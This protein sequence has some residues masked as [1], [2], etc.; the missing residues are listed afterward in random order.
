MKV[1]QPRFDFVEMTVKGY[2]FTWKNRHFIAP[3]A[4]IP[5]LVKL[6]CL[7]LIIALD[8][9]DN[10]LRQGLVLLPSF[11][12]EGWLLAYL[13]RVAVFNE[14]GT[15]G[16]GGENLRDE[17]FLRARA[18]DVLAGTLVYV[19]IK[20]LLSLISGL[21][22]NAEGGTVTIHAVPSPSPQM[23]VLALLM[24]GFMLWAFRFLWLNVVVA[25]GY[26]VWDFV[27]KAQGGLLSFSMLGTW[28]LCFVPFAMVLM[29]ISGLLLEIFPP[30][31]NEPAAVYKF[32]MT[33][34]QSAIDT[35]IAIVT[36]TAMAYGTQSLMKGEYPKP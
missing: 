33:G 23:M 16:R 8:L 12:L 24:F 17:I 9:S 20:L 35:V 6:G 4:G 26:G 5:V 34:V 27:R 13:V 21:A 31:G 32:L 11:F 1:T 14:R 19:L 3:L 25:L 2:T 30:N 29:L 15:G 18:R 10:F 7:S 36:A 28:L 22:M